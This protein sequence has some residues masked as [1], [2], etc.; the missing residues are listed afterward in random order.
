MW[1]SVC[2]DNVYKRLLKVSS[3][4]KLIVL[5]KIAVQGWVDFHCEHGL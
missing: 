1:L 2:V 5:H 3:L 4:D